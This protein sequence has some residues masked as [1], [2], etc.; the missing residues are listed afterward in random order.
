M[1]G[2]TVCYNLMEDGKEPQQLRNWS[3]QQSEDRSDHQAPGN[4]PSSGDQTESEKGKEEVRSVSPSISL[5]SPEINSS[6][7]FTER[8]CK[9]VTFSEGKKKLRKEL[10]D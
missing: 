9:S 5:S 4:N 6:K 10:S 3:L 2:H 8:I 1:N 7:S